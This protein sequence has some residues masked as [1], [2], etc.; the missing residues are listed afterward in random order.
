MTLHC[1]NVSKVY[2]WVILNLTA[3]KNIF[4][5][6][7]CTENIQTAVNLNHSLAI[8]ISTLEEKNCKVRI[9]EKN[10]EVNGFT[11]AAI[12]KPIIFIPVNIDITD[13]CTNKSVCNIT[14]EVVL[15]DFEPTIICLPEELGEK[16]IKCS[17]LK[18]N[19]T[20]TNILI[21]NENNCEEEAC[22]SLDLSFFVCVDVEVRED[23][24]VNLEATTQNP[25]EEIP[26]ELSFGCNNEVLF[27]PN[28]SFFPQIQVTTTTTT[29][30]ITTTTTTPVPKINVSID[31]PTGVVAGQSVTYTITVSNPNT[32]TVSDIVVVDTISPFV[33]FISISSLGDIFL[34]QNS[35]TCNCSF[36][37]TQNTLTCNVGTLS[38]GDSCEFTYSGTI[39]TQA[40]GTIT[41]NL[42]TIYIAGSKTQVS[43]TS[44]PVFGLKFEVEAPPSIL[45][46]Q[47]I[48]YTISFSNSGTNTIDNITITDIIPSHIVSNT[49][50]ISSSCSNCSITNSN[51]S[52]N[53]NSLTPASSCNITIEGE[54][55]PTTSNLT[56][57]SNEVTLTSSSFSQ[58]LS[59]SVQT[60]VN[61]PYAFV[62]DNGSSQVSVIDAISLN[63]ITTLNGFNTP[64][65]DAFTPDGSYAFVSNFESNN[66]SVIEVNTFAVTT[67]ITVGSGPFGVAISFS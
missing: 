43:Q 60:K 56:V 37:S 23:V 32:F 45:P 24:K 13:T 67:T 55:S 29:A 58:T 4:L 52:C 31:G 30:P 48:I 42:I 38:P 44:N 57:I 8:E 47:T 6:L 54:V 17:I 21:L 50:T 15:S 33:E 40:T 9:L 19:V 7:N 5:P 36:N 53:I 10:I 61:R 51:V 27:P 12:I 66:V 26:L 11:Q 22:F 41:V 1:V 28:C 16:N 64:A 63:L 59:S 18:L 39:S 2:D 3:N 14:T 46:E 62:C 35:N 34:T 49:I 20:T 65:F 25:R